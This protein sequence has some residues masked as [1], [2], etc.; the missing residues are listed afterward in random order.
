LDDETSAERARRYRAN[1][2]EIR[3]AAS[4]IKHPES[5]AALLRLASTY[6]RLVARLESESENPG[7]VEEER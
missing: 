1:A 5:R 3:S 6:E 2:E 7:L 4:D